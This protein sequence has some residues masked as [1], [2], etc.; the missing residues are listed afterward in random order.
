MPWPAA[1]AWV[2]S[3]GASPSGAALVA[4]VE[5]G[6]H[7]HVAPGIGQCAAG[8]CLEP[9]ERNAY[10]DGQRGREHGIPDDLR[11]GRRI[12][13]A[14]AARGRVRSAGLGVAAAS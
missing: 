10:H 12:A 13:A 2:V 9:T 3:A 4:L 7:A 6:S 14:V 5:G 8:P 11:H 1:D